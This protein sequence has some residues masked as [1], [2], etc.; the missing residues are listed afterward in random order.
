MALNTVRISP[1]VVEFTDVKVG[2]VYKTAVTVTNIGKSSKRMRMVEPISKLFRLKVNNPCTSIAPGLSMT[3]CLDFS[4]DKEEEVRDRLLL[5]L[6]DEATEIP[7]SAFPMACSLQ[8]ESLVDFGSVLANSQVISKEV[9]LTNQGSAPGVFEVLYN[10]DTSVRLSPCSG[11]VSPGAT[12]WLK[13]ELCT[14]RARHI[15]EQALVKLQ[16]RADVVLRVCADVQEQS[17]ELRDPEGRPLSCLRFG[18]L[19]FGTAAVETLVVRNSGPQACHWVVVLLEDAPGTELGTDIQKSTD[20]ALAERSAT[21]AAVTMDARRVITCVP[22]EGGL[23]PYEATSLSVC[24]SPV[25]RNSEGNSRQDYSLF[26]LFDIV[27]RKHGFTHQ[28]LCNGGGAVELAVTGSGLPMA[29]VPSPSLHFS[30]QDCTPGQRVSMLCVLQNQSH[31]LPLNFRFCKIA[32]FISDPPTGVIAPGQSLDV[33]LSFSPHQMGRFQVHQPLKVIGQVAHVN[34]SSVKLRLCSFHTVTLHLSAVCHAPKAGPRGLVPSGILCSAKT[35]LHRHRQSE[36]NGAGLL[37]LPDKPMARLRSGF[38]DTP[39]RTIFTGVERYRYTDPDY[40]YSEEEEQQRQ[41]HRQLYLTFIRSLRETRLHR[42]SQRSHREV[43][44]EVD[45]GIRPAEGLSP[46][47]LSL[48]DL[49]T[50]QSPAEGCCQQS[51]SL[52][53]CALAAMKISPTSRQVETGGMNAVPST[54]QEVSEC[55]SKLSAQQLHQVVVGPSSVD[56][57]EVCVQSVCVRPLE[58]VN[59]LG[60]CVWVQLELDCPELQRSSPLSYV[61]PPVSRATL[62]LTFQTSKLG[63]FYKSVS[64][65][66]NSCHPGQVLVVAR[67]VPLALELSAPEVLLGPAHSLLAQSGYRSSVTLRN[68][69]NQVADFTWKPIITEEGMAFS[70]R[71]ATGCVEAHSELECEVVWHPSFCSLLEGSFQLWVHLGNTTHLRCVAKLGRSSVHL[72]EKQLVF[73]SVAL[74]L[75]SS[76]TSRLLNTGHN[77]VHYQ[78]LDVCPLPGMTVSP[79]EGVVP[80]G[81]QVDITVLL[82][83]AAVMKFHTRVKIA[84]RNM[85]ALEL[86]VGGSVEPPLVDIDVS[87]FLFQGVY[88]GSSHR[89]PF[90]LQNRSPALAQVHF[91]LEQHTDFTILLPSSVTGPEAGPNEYVCDLQ[92]LQTVDCALVFSPKQV[93]SHDFILPVTVNGVG[94]RST[95]AGSAPSATASDGHMVTPRP[96]AVTLETVSRRVQ[97]TALRGPLEMFPSTLQFNVELLEPGSTTLTQTVELRSVSQECVFWKLD[98]SA[99]SAL[100]GGARLFLSPAGGSLLPGNTLTITVTME[101]HNLAPVPGGRVQLSLPLSAGGEERMEV[102]GGRRAYR[103]LRICLTLCPPTITFLPPRVLLT[104][105]PLDTPTTAT[106]T[107]LTSGYPRG[108]SVCVEVE[109]V[110]LDDGT[111][112]RPLTVSQ[113]RG[114]PLPAQPQGQARGHTQDSWSSMVYTVTFC[115]PQPLSLCSHI[116]FIDHLNNRFQVEVCATADNCLLSVWPHLALHRSQQHIVLRSGHVNS[117]SGG[118]Q[119]AGE[120]VL[121]PCYSPSSASHYTGSTSS[122]FAVLSSSCSRTLSDSA[123][124]SRSDSVCDT[125]A[126]TKEV[127]PLSEGIP[128]F[129]R[130]ES[131]EGLYYHSVLLAVQKWFS[132]FGW[133]RGPNPISLPHTLRR[134]ECK[135]E[136]MEVGPGN[137]RSF[138]VSQRRGV[139]TVNDMLLHLAATSL[140]GACSSQSLPSNPT[141]RLRELLDQHSNLLAF[142]R[143]QGACLS[144]IRPEYLLDLQEFNHWRTQQA[145]T[146]QRT[147]DYSSCDYEA[148]S[149]RAWTDVLLQTYKVL[150]LRRVREVCRGPQGPEG[151]EHGAVPRIDPSPL[152]SNV[153]SPWERRLLSW[154]NLHYHNTRTS[155]WAS[156]SCRGG[157]P[158]ARWVVNFELDLA[159]G[160]VLAATLAAYCPFLIG[161][162]FQRMYTNSCSLEQNLHNNIILCQALQTLVLGLDIQPT[163]LSDPNPVLML[164]LCV[165]LYEHLPQYL[166]RRTLT[167]SGSLHS[168]FTKQVRL[169]SPSS[170]PLLYQASLLGKDAHLFSLP[171]GPSI[172]IP[173]K[174]QRVAELTL[175]YSGSFLRPREAALLLS[176]RSAVGPRGAP[177]VFSL[178]TQVT[179]VTPSG[180]VK[181][182][183]P[184]YQLK[185]LQIRVTNPFSQDAS[186][187][188]VLVESRE[189]PL[190][191]DDNQS[192]KENLIQQV[193]S[194]A[195]HNPNPD[196]TTSQTEIIDTEHASGNEN[197]QGERRGVCEF[198]TPCSTVCVQAGQ[199]EVLELHYLPFQL[200]QRYCSLL[201]ACTQV[202]E[203]VY[204]VK[205]V[206]ELPVPSP[207]P[208]QPSPWTVAPSS[209]PSGECEAGPTLTL[210]CGVGEVCEVVVCVPLVNVQWERALAAVGQRRMSEEELWRRALTHTLDSS[211]VRAAV[212]ANTLTDS[213]AL[214]V[215]GPAQNQKVDYSVEVSLPEHFT[216]TDSISLPVARHATLPQDSPA[217]SEVVLLPLRFQAGSAG[218]FCCQLVL[219]SWR[220]VRLHLLEAQVTAP[221]QHAH[222]DFRTPAHQ[223]V[224]QDIPLNNESSRDWRLRG[225]V[226]GRGF[227]G[228]PVLYLR[229]G[230]KAPYPLTFQPSAQGVVTGKLSLLND[231]NGTE[232]IFTLRGRGER[233]LPVEQLVLHCPVRQT[234]SCTLHV[235]NYSQD[236]L[237]CKVES[238]LSFVSGAA[239]LQ[240]EPGCTHPYTLSV[241]PWKRGKH[242]GSVSFVAMEMEDVQEIDGPN[243]VGSSRQYEVW[244]SLEVACSPAPPTK[245]VVVQCAVQSCVT[246]E[247]SVSNPQAESLLLGVCLEGEDLSGDSQVCLPA[248]GS[249]TYKATYS[250]ARVGHRTGSVIFQSELLGEFWYQLNLLAEPPVPTTLPQSSCELGKWIREWISLVNP[251][252]ETLE[253]NVV[254]SNPRNYTVELGTNSPLIVAPHSSTK[255]PVRFSPSAIG[256][257]NHT[258]NI[259]FT[260]PQVMEWRFVL[261]GRGLVPGSMD[262][263][264]VSSLIGSHSSLILPFT[265]PTEHS[266][267][268]HISLSDEDPS[269]GACPSAQRDSQ[270]F[271]IP[272]KHTHGVRV[273]AGASVDIPVVFAPDSMQLHQTWLCLRLHP[274]QDLQDQEH[275]PSQQ[276]QE[277]THTPSQQDQEHTHT[278]SQQDENQ[279]HTHMDKSGC[280][281]ENGRVSAVCWVYPIHGIPEAPPKP[282]QPAEV[283]CEAGRRIEER[284]EVQFTACIPVSSTPANNQDQSSNTA[285]ITGS[286][287]CLEDFLCELRY[288]GEEERAWLEGCVSVSLLEGK[289][290]P[291]SGIVSLSLGLTYAPHRPLRC[292]A[293][294]VVR[295]V[296]GGLWKFPIRLVSTAPQVDDVIIIEA[297]GLHKTSAVGFRLTSQTSHPEAFTAGFLPGS[298]REF[299]V[300]PPSGELLPVG[301]A[302]TLLTVSFTPSMYSK[303]HL[304]T[305]LVQTPD[306][307]WTY[308][309]RGM[310][311]A[312][313][314]PLSPGSTNGI[315]SSGTRPS[316]VR[317]RNFVAR[318]LQLPALANSSP[319]RRR[320]GTFVA[321][322]Q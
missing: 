3:G 74:N 303:K 148:L 117:D 22:N 298:G 137:G 102:D 322:T 313:T 97:A 203:L 62:P 294:L 51:Q 96:P 194:K 233:P 6:E 1:P 9:S 152:A 220:D 92:A 10:G 173:P 264:S 119:L 316:E 189:N 83:P 125:Q 37:A 246:V 98:C 103:E 284:I 66:V 315:S 154:L 29:L 75:P 285:P 277:H 139:K 144:H 202:G 150:V 265:N 116:T 67:V 196:S 224:T 239:T 274:L 89:V 288:H 319:F 115:C 42:S 174:G 5:L 318:N 108:T 171:H 314:P 281:V 76:R 166:P 30:F 269:G 198:H 13:V 178:K 267:L 305:L 48:Q 175:R 38:P 218:L 187:R 82:T 275:T 146:E 234:S 100:L 263:L 112:L 80:V 193:T 147:I 227:S 59:H 107:L 266:A 226:A 249:L 145:P 308:E 282:S 200:G 26:L 235:P 279:G 229:A 183:S 134:V 236:T 156:D 39:H 122:T 250:P 32:N 195:D 188:V 17:L 61:L 297:R 300:D 90:R 247:I 53:S 34:S 317:Q 215:H 41:R 142:L 16:G 243:A 222:L 287:V 4:P 47:R 201:M 240:I 95:S 68:R 157:V 206:C 262:P 85:K 219:R 15:R 57:G 261:S 164:M 44:D 245:V 87:S 7:L 172:T 36:K 23:G 50:N 190:Q 270:V 124:D 320:A 45:I 149:T 161:S 133:P 94:S 8:M 78:V 302:G 179:H 99:A 311:P 49:E 213:Q 211:S 46:P 55:S 159:D 84:L 292:L 301:S 185:K 129:P 28:R 204:L 79:S 81:G 242:T 197:D 321:D 31:L 109:E 126:G 186:F 155:I 14:N 254:N 165:H 258:A 151:V 2:E 43:E 11:V 225:V 214:L 19:Y 230:E 64:Y 160:L 121:Q 256:A 307:Q 105:A 141:L 293:E 231:S 309:V 209:G 24:F 54:R 60:V 70:I 35:R 237:T 252:D 180:V 106:L 184:C 291:Q 210:R 296:T 182:R 158:S 12:Q 278:P 110:E 114:G 25:S 113:P 111:R 170:C 167:L 52:T 101:T 91:L 273:C 104:P 56:F 72:S 216:V 58:L 123:L 276:D 228:P 132:L 289:R 20:A 238:D 168:S 169:R 299:T 131:E 18:S 304:A 138:R 136:T 73:G 135:V 27:E 65:T 223:P 257:G 21:N 306:M 208:S 140:P 162:H 163:E 63:D 77:H 120:A 312:Y 244:F 241:S 33:V 127:W 268:L 153:Y 272:L 88:A 176:P 143:A 86:R 128:S 221:G 177:L 69:G 290:D 181:C 259:T 191:L 283:V 232:H 253:L 217:D 71:P 310:A 93:G 295:C 271:C 205:G 207:L 286:L 40:S 212:A 280:V 248:A 199:T 130:A 260:C 118:S 192:I 255:V 251:T